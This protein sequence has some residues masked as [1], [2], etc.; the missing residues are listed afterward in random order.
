MPEEEKE[1][2]FWPDKIAKELVK[3]WKSERQVIV[4]GTSMSGDPH[5]GNAN[6]IIRGDVVVRAIKDLREKAELIWISDDL[7]PFRSVPAD[8]PEKLENYLGIPAVK[9]PDI[10]DGK[11]KN[12]SDHFEQKFLGQLK[13][14]GVKPKVLLATDMYKKGMYNEVMKI[15]MKK[16]NEIVQIL[17]KFRKNHLPEDW[18]PIDVTCEKC[19]KISTT[20]ILNYDEKNL[21]VEYFCNPEEVLLHKKNPVKGCGERRWKSILN[22]G[23]KLTWRVEWPARWALLK[24][25]CEPFGKEHAAAGGSWDTGKEIVKKIF[26]WKAPYPVVYEHFLVNGEKMSKSRGNVLTVMDMLKYMKIEHLRYWMYQGRLTIAKD[27]NLKNIVPNLFNEYDKAERIFFEKESTGNDKRDNNYKRAYQLSSIK[28]PKSPSFQIEFDKLE[29]IVKILPGKNQLEFAME[30]LKE[31]NVKKKFSE[32]EKKEL[33]LR[34]EFAKRWYDDFVRPKEPVKKLEI[35][36]K[37]EKGFAAL[38]SEIEKAKNGDE[39]QEKIFQIIKNNNLDQR[40]FFKKTY[41]VLLN[42]ERGPRLGPYIIEAGKKEI[43]NKLKKAIK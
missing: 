22:G 2:D 35:D 40:D 29:E 41:S 24:A 27:I 39:L 36:E 32:K 13:I 26:G 3:N 15:A 7:D 14:I 19:G 5:I 1:Y 25:T 43:I 6:D 9:I 18:Y 34:L 31:W 20:K 33:S 42:S 30:K 23:A 8:M 12:F 37:M 17:N 28:I 4:T 11:H 38:I 10:F 16:R 21:K